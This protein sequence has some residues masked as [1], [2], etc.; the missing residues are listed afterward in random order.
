M[1]AINIFYLR[2]KRAV[3]SGGKV[4]VKS[5]KTQTGGFLGS[6]LA[7]IG[8]PIAIEA[9]KRMIGSGGPRTRLSESF[10]VDG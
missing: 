10:E 6:L 3:Q 9:F 7:S 2:N 8:I 4:I 5:T 1:I